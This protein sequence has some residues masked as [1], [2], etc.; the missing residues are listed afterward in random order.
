MCRPTNGD[1][2]P[3]FRFG[4]NL[5]RRR[6][7]LLGAAA[8]LERHKSV[9]Y[10]ATMR[11]KFFSGVDTF[12]YSG[13][14]ELL[15]QKNDTIWGGKFQINTSGDTM[16]HDHLYWLYDLK[17]LYAINGNTDTITTYNPHKGESWGFESDNRSGLRWD[18]F[19]RPER[20]S[21][22]AGYGMNIIGTQVVEGTPCYELVIM[23]P[24]DGA[25]TE[26]TKETSWLFVSQKDSIPIR[27]QWLNTYQG[28][29]QYNELL[30]HQYT[31]DKVRDIALSPSVKKKYVLWKY[32]ADTNEAKLLDSGAVAPP[33]RVRCTNWGAT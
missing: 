6:S 8:A 27:Q 17:T 9:E 20:L 3:C 28:N 21:G 19:L 32:K 23:F 16:T 25:G 5:S 2:V 1:K 31:F 22:K 30:I 33:L 24:D 11:M 7:I 18:N 10:T 26:L 4:N 12:S 29:Y 15:R 13:N 14:C